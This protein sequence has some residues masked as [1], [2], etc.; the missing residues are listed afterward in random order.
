MDQR[1]SPRLLGDFSFP[2]PANDAAAIT[3]CASATD[4]KMPSSAQELDLKTLNGLPR[5]IRDLIYDA[6][7]DGDIMVIFGR[8]GCLPVHREGPSHPE[9]TSQVAS[10]HRLVFPGSHSPFGT[11]SVDSASK[12]ASPKMQ[13]TTSLQQAEMT[14]YGASVRKALRICVPRTSQDV[15]TPTDEAVVLDSSTCKTPLIGILL[16]SKQNHDEATSILYKSCTFLFEDFDLSV[17]FINATS[18]ENLKHIRKIAVYYPQELEGFP[19]TR[20]AIH[21]SPDLDAYHQQSAS[22]LLDAESRLRRAL[23]SFQADPADDYALAYN[24][25]T[26][27]SSSIPPS[28]PDSELP[29]RWL[30]GVLCRMV[31]VNMPLAEELTIWVGDTLELE[32]N[33]RRCETYE[34]ALLQFAGLGKIDALSVKKYGEIFDNSNDENARW[35]ELNWMKTRTL[36]GVEEIIRS[37]DHGALDRQSRVLPDFDE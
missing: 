19:E 31:V 21:D 28:A 22:H 32:Y 25:A 16:A 17:K 36:S 13:T 2:S 18:F 4:A 8:R 20:R 7:F 9:E 34:A 6:T 11:Q 12:T 14:A 26:Q 23:I 29:A 5:E 27:G 1:T 3:Q 15:N 10:K 33:S 37:G 35:H 24:I 30:F